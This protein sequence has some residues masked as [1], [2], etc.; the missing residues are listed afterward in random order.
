MG[1]GDAL[2]ET[3]WSLGGGFLRI[4][5]EKHRR[6][7]KRLIAIKAVQAKVVLCLV[8]YKK[9]M[10]DVDLKMFRFVMPN[11]P[12]QPNDNDCGVFVMKFMDS[13]SNGGLSKFIDVGK[14]NKYRLK[15]LGRLLLSSH[16]AHRQ[17][18]LVD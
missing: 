11:V 12:S 10:V 9:Q 7:G 5:G 15:I 16:N 13:W 1:K 6:S 2:K 3:Y 17:R 18:F 4:F 14:I 8:A